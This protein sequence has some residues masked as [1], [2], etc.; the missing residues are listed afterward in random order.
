MEPL[1]SSLLG[2]GKRY[3]KKEK[4]QRN[5][6]GKSNTVHSSS[7]CVTVSQKFILLQRYNPSL[8]MLL[9]KEVVKELKRSLV[10]RR[11]LGKEKV[12]GPIVM[13]HM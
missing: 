8:E 10:G 12:R 2:R 6:G 7:R 4:E 1:Y 13:C 11:V 3:L 5:T 9:A